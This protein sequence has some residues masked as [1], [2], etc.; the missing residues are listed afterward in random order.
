MTSPALCP[1]WVLHNNSNVCLAVDRAWFV[2]YTPFQSTVQTGLMGGILNVGGQTL[3]VHGV[4]TVEIPVKIKD[5]T[6]RKLSIDN[7]VHVPDYCCNII[8][9]PI[10]SIADGT[11][12]P[13]HSRDGYLKSS[14]GPVRGLLRMRHQLACLVLSGPPVGPVTRRSSFE[15]G[16]PLGVGAN[17]S[18]SERKF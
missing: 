15:N 10:L 9:A 6:H 8:G 3:A 5:R 4:G 13:G 1:D 18:D 16:R 12:F 11:R 17:W 2:S 7:V 14:N